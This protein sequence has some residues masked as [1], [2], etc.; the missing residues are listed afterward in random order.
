MSMWQAALFG[1]LGG[2][3]R[4]LLAFYHLIGEWHHARRRHLSSCETG[5]RKRLAESIDLAAESIAMAA[6]VT[7]GAVAGVILSE[8]DTITGVAGAI[9]AGAAAPAILSQLGQLAP[10]QNLVMGNGDAKQQPPNDDTISED[11]VGGS[12]MLATEADSANDN[13]VEQEE[14]PRAN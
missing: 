13:K 5:P 7:L 2:T 6:Q 4:G 12:A 9:L 10:V 3:V 8:T 11:V 1:G 14:A